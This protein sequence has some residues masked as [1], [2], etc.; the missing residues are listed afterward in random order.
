MHVPQNS[1][2]YCDPPYAETTDY[3]AVDAFDSEKFFT[4]CREKHKEGHTVF[5]SEY[6]APNDFTLVF[7]K[8]VSNQLSDKNRKAARVEKLFKLV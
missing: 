8:V 7:E 2:I 3:K 5:I 4:W 1:V 6:Q